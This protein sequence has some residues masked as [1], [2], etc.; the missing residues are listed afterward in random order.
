M[1]V[2]YVIILSDQGVQPHWLRDG[3]GVVGVYPAPDYKSKFQKKK[4]LLKIYNTP[5]FFTYSLAYIK[6]YAYLCTL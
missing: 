4:F 6:N 2:N 1:F 3:E 5:K